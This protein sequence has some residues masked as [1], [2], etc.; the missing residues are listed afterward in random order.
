LNTPHNWK[1]YRN[2]RARNEEVDKH[3]NVH[4]KTKKEMYKAVDD[5]MK[6]I[7]TGKVPK[8]QIINGMTGEMIGWPEK[9]E[10]HWQPSGI[11]YALRDLK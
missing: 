2:W 7:R 11:T 10:Y 9:S 3:G 6:I 8:F 4:A 1:K 5:A